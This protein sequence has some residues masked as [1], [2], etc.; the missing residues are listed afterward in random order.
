MG[1]AAKNTYNL[2]RV[3]ENYV[4]TNIILAAFPYCWQKISM[5]PVQ[6]HIKTDN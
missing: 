4:K 5:Q 2:F 6:W 1:T 3:A